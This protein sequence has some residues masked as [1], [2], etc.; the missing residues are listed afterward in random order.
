MT[1]VGLR[2]KEERMQRTSVGD[3]STS[4]ESEPDRRR[5]S[6]FVSS[7]KVAWVMLAGTT[8]TEGDR[9]ARPLST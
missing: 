1:R 9:F 7:G 2:E 4:Q 6:N 5:H 8:M 3:D